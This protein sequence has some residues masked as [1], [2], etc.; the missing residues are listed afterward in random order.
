[1]TNGFKIAFTAFALTAGLIKGVPTMA[2]PAPAAELNVSY[3]HTADL[4]LTTDAGRRVLD[5]R[6]VT[7]A[8]A[9]C[10]AASD[11]DLEGKN[12]VR[13]CRAE[14]LARARADRDTV[15]AA[16]DRGTIIALTAAR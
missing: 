12:D 9:V 14:T 5:N 10:G 4:D 6:L 7:A 8:R 11:V 3:V 13:K 15:L 2:A 1:M 16:A